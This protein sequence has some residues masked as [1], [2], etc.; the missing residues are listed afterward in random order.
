MNLELLEQL[1]RTIAMNE[2]AQR[3][4]RFIVLAAIS[5]IQT[6]VQMICG[7]QIAE[8]YDCVGSEAMT[9][10]AQ[11]TE[12]YISRESEKLG[13]AMVN[14]IHGESREIG[15]RRGRRRQ[16]SDWEI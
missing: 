15:P 1:M 2:R 3:R 9:K 5:K 16:W 12:D 4:F 10:H 8:A 11:A 7:A 14:F 13:L 6:T